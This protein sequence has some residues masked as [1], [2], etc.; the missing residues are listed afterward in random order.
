MKLSKILGIFSRIK[1]SLTLEAANRLYKAMV[2][3]VLDYC[4]AV[5]HECGQ[6][7]SDKIGRLQRQRRGS[8]TSKL[9]QNYHLIKL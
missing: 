9:P 2:L 5:W 3:L 4:D 8:S 1:P 7:N 6:G